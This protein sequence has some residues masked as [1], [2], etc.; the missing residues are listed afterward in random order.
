MASSFMKNVFSVGLLSIQNDEDAD[1]I[2][3]NLSTE[4]M[5]LT[6]IAWRVP[7]D[8]A[9]AKPSGGRRHSRREEAATLAWAFS[10]AGGSP[11]QASR[12]VRPPSPDPGGR[13]LPDRTGSLAGRLPSRRGSPALAWAFLKAGGPR[14][15]SGEQPGGVAPDPGRAPPPVDGPDGPRRQLARGTMT[16]PGF[17]E[18][19]ARVARLA[20][21]PGEGVC[22]IVEGRARPPHRGLKM[23]AG[24]RPR[25]RSARVAAL[26]GRS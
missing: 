22:P 11:D 8:A 25:R 2:F 19:S 3:R 21:P 12:A 17:L 26:P 5:M 16:P 14:Q 4:T 10:R 1:H 13:A 24:R 7:V 23:R 18:G 15:I 20:K 9:V 6:E